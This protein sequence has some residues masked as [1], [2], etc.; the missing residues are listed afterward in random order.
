MRPWL[1]ERFQSATSLP[2]KTKLLAHLSC[3]HRA[4][5]PR[6]SSA[7][8]RILRQEAIDCGAPRLEFPA[9]YQRSHRPGFEPRRR[10]FYLVDAKHSE[11]RDG[12][13]SAINMT[14]VKS[15]WNFNLDNFPI[16]RLRKATN[17]RERWSEISFAPFKE[18]KKYS[19]AISL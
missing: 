16:S 14:A 4:S 6:A 2:G 9:C 17:E 10:D 19:Y 11:S 7:Q 13:N 5:G 1:S 8:Y 15:S 12:Y 18:C 3:W